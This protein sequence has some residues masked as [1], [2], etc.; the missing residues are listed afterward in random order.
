MKRGEDSS[1]MLVDSSWTRFN[2]SAWQ[3]VCLNGFTVQRSPLIRGAVPEIAKTSSR[4]IF[5]SMEDIVWNY[6][7]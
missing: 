5:V 6:E 3:A 4:N 1:S 7:L 2:G